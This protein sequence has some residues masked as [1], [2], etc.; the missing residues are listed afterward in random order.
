MHNNDYNISSFVDNL[1]PAHIVS[2]NPELVEFVKVYALYLEKENKSGFYLN[3]LDLQRDIDLIETALLTE[4]QNEIGTPIPRSFSADPRVFYK[5]LVDFYK[6]R[7]TPESIEAFFRIIYDEPV[8]IYFPKD[9][10]LYPSDGRWTDQQAAITADPSA[11]NP[12]HTWTLSSGLTTLGIADDAG[13]MPKFDN[14]IITVNGTVRT[15]VTFSIRQLT[16][17]PYTVLYEATFG[18]ALV[19]GDVIKSYH[20]GLF[21]T[22]DGHPSAKKYMQDSKFYQRFSYVLKTGKNI[23]DW[24]NAFIRLIH[25]AGFNFFGEI[26]I[27]LY[28]PKTDYAIPGQPLSNQYG[29]QGSGLP[30]AIYAAYLTQHTMAWETDHYM[31]E[32]TVITL[33]GQYTDASHDNPMWFG[34]SFDNLKYHNYR[35]LQDYADLTIQDVI[36]KNIKTQLGCHIT[37]TTIP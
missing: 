20:A 2:A 30:F 10:I 34:Y 29:Y 22:H 3:Q 21:I 12:A 8:I 33:P 24:K 35:P 26:L 6:S 15:D 13:F 31:I 14:D 17:S 16:S 36:N 23:A 7:G 19:S 18:T 27:D 11:F 32:K 28:M 25:P 1:I 9:D 4:L 37:Q 5:H